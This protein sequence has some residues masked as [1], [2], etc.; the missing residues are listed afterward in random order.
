[1]MIGIATNTIHAPSRNLVNE[2]ITSTTNVATAPTVLMTMERFHSL[3]R[4]R[5]LPLLLQPM[6]DHARLRQRERGE[7]ADDVEL[8]QPVEVGVEHHDQQAREGAQHDDAVGEDEAVPAVR[9]LPRHEP[10]ARQDRRQPREVLIR[11]VRRQDQDRAGEELHDVEDGPATEHRMGD[12]SDN[13]PFLADRDPL[14]VGRQERDTQEHRHRDGSH[15]GERLRGVL[16]PWVTE[17]GHPVGDRL[18]PGE[19]RGAGRE[20]VQDHEQRDRRGHLRELV[21]RLQLFHH[22]RT[23]AEHA[24]GEPDD[25]E[26][27][28]RHDERV[29]RNGEERPRLADP[30][31]VRQRDQDDEPDRELHLD[32]RQARGAPRS[33]RTRRRPRTPRPSARSP[34]ATRRLPAV[35][36]TCPGSPGSR[37]RNRR[38]SGTPAR[39]GGRRTRRSPAGPRSRAAIGIA[40]RVPMTLAMS[41]TRRISSVAYATEE[42]A[43]DENTGSARTFGRR[44]CSRPS[45]GT[46]R[47]R[48]SRFTTSLI[49]PFDVVRSIGGC[50]PVGSATHR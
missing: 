37:C 46:A 17:R 43:S 10:V 18:D 24:L 27:E 33:A 7:H 49:G 1:M 16:R 20:R 29:R 35:R 11:G 5:P 41:S 8:D 15:D 31:Q 19:R 50:Y 38:R 42:R 44:V 23:A 3:V 36:G 39:S 13:R 6:A 4:L 12:L 25:Q 40:Y 47:P 45:L 14:D 32:R 26:R 28:D 21:G 9:E 22:D 30:S 34:S 48:N 2:T